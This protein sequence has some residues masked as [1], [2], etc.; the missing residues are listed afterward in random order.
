MEADATNVASIVNVFSLYG[1]SVPS[2]KKYETI[3]SHVACLF[4]EER[5]KRGVSLNFLAEKAGLSRQ[6]ISFVEQE[7]RTP[8]LDTLLRIADALEVDLEKIIAR[9][10][11]LAGE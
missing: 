9:A 5:K 2:N 10:R 8:N 4:K 11:K 1:F 7:M 6:T 3:C